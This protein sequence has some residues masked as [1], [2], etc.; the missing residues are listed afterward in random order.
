MRSTGGGYCIGSEQNDECVILF[1]FDREHNSPKL[2]DARVHSKFA[3]E[4]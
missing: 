1:N 2:I 3:L 4:N